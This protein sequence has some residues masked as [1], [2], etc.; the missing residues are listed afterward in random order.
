MTAQE[1]GGETR[2]VLGLLHCRWRESHCQ[3]QALRPH[4]PTTTTKKQ[5]KIEIKK[6]NN[7]HK[8]VV[9]REIYP[10][11]RVQGSDGVARVGE[12]ACMVVMK[13]WLPM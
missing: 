10:C 12:K 1:R 7:P 11:N 5:I 6:K 13:Q 2:S 4:P 8:R 3:G 9:T